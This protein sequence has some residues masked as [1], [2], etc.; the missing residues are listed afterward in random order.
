[1]ANIILRAAEPKTLARAVSTTTSSQAYGWGSLLQEY[2]SSGST[3]KGRFM[4]F[5]DVPKLMLTA[6]RLLPQEV[7]EFV[8][9]LAGFAA[10]DRE[11]SV[12]LLRAAVPTLC[13][14]INASPSRTF[15][16]IYLD[17]AWHTLGYSLF[18]GKSPTNLNQI[19]TAKMLIGRLDTRAIASGFPGVYQ[20]DWEK[21]ARL[22]IFIG[23]VLPQKHKEICRMLDWEALDKATELAW[24]GFPHELE[25]LIKSL[26]ARRGAASGRDVVTEPVRSWVARRLEFVERIPPLLMIV[27]PATAAKL[28]REGASYDLMISSG[29]GWG[30][31]AHALWRIY[32]ID[33]QLASMIVTESRASLA[34]G[35]TKLQSL[36]SEHLGIFCKV[37]N[38]VAPGSLRMVTENIDVATAASY[39]S[40]VIAKKPKRSRNA[41][42]ALLTSLEPLTPA[43]TRL[44]T[45]LGLRRVRNGPSGKRETK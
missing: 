39:W 1:L 10:L 2:W 3:V 9:L 18:D 17:L 15:N 35:F 13:S 44:S 19:R 42:E 33:S 14:A 38:K 34:S 40:S 43:L 20:S 12:K 23:W 24:S 45:Q 5:L 41:L 27:A 36:D 16:Q 37:I 11:F 22:L 28:L 32:A 26:L 29:Y 7:I 8:H 21:S 31:A 30:P 6:R 4:A 25:I